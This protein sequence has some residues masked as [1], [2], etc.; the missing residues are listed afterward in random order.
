M[1]SFLIDWGIVTTGAYLPRRLFLEGAWR[2]PVEA[3]A[4]PETDFDLPSNAR[5]GRDDMALWR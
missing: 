2:S 1:A 4:V 3:H 5:Q